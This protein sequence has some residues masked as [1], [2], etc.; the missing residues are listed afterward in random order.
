MKL[1]FKSTVLTATLIVAISCNSS[2]E[3]EP[4]YNQFNYVGYELNCPVVSYEENTYDA[5]SKFG[6]I[7]KDSEI[8]ETV[9][10]EFDKNGYLVKETT[11]NSEREISTL[12]KFLY[13]NSNTSVEDQEYS[14]DGALSS[15]T[16]YELK[17][18]GS[19]LSRIEYDAYGNEIASDKY[20]YKGELI[21]KQSSK[22]EYYSYEILY[23]I[24]GSAYKSYSVYNEGE[25]NSVYKYSKFDLNREISG[26]IY[27]ASG[28]KEGEFCTTYYKK[29]KIKSYWLRFDEYPDQIRYGCD[30]NDKRLITQTIVDGDITQYEY[31]YD[32]RGNWIR[33]TEFEGENKKPVEIVE[34]TIIY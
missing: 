13:S 20:E 15:I 19:I 25:L 3:I 28:E 6:E 2:T 30:Y 24:E 27:N 17:A 9:V 29:G 21:S 31:E 4:A 5:A 23:V 26:I 16:K 14:Y 33:R 18:S 34:R 11:Y 8:K 7:V 32:K 12:H 1:L 22:T 10:V